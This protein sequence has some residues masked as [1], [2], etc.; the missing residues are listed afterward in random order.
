MAYSPHMIKNTRSVLLPD[1]LS[2][3]NYV[4][5]IVYIQDIQLYTDLWTSVKWCGH[6]LYVY[7]FEVWCGK[8]EII[9]LNRTKKSN[10][11]NVLNELANIPNF[12]SMY[13]KKQQTF[14]YLVTVNPINHIIRNDINVLN[15]LVNIPHFNSVHLTRMHSSGM[16][17]ILL[18][19][20]EGRGQV[21]AQGGCPAQ[22][23]CLP[24]G[25]LSGGVCLGG[26]CPGGYLPAGVYLWG[27]GGSVCPGGMSA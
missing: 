14:L 1:I 7:F 18:Q 15:Q 17:T 8:Y 16:R 4:R 21:S 23:G 22:E 27:S 5:E 9:T 20:R 11:V 25:C 2:K 3:W 12:K 10:V 19:W 6:V 13:L 26:V 24:G